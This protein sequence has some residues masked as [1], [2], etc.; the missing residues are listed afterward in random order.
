MQ[1]LLKALREDGEQADFFRNFAP[2]AGVLT[3]EERRP[4]ILECSFSH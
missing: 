2:F 1:A 4:L 3:T